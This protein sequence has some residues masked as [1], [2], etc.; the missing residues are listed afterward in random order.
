M[1]AGLQA[2]LYNLSYRPSQLD[3]VIPA[4]WKGISRHVNT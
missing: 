4:C 2:D 3:L 1:Y